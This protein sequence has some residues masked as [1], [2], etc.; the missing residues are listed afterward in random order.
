MYVQIAM[1]IYQQLIW[2]GIMM[3]NK[4]E[5]H[6]EKQYVLTGL[7]DVGFTRHLANWPSGLADI[8][9]APCEYKPE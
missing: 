9:A 1:L 3:E 4:K 5:G 7:Q 2:G 6:F 8:V